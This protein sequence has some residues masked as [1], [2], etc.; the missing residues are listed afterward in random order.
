MESKERSVTWACE[1]LDVKDKPDSFYANLVGMYEIDEPNK[2]IVFRVVLM[3]KWPT[4]TKQEILLLKERTRKIFNHIPEGDDIVD[5]KFE[6]YLKRY[7]NLP[8]DRLESKITILQHKQP[9]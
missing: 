9:K 4:S 1:A 5:P 3:V 8:F 2:K 6:F 7:N